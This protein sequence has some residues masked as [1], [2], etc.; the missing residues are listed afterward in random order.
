M[1][2]VKTR[3]LAS[4]LAFLFVAAAS[5]SPSLAGQNSGGLLGGGVG[6]AL[7]GAAG[8]ISGTMNGVAGSLG[9]GAGVNSAGSQF[10]GPTDTL[11]SILASP[12]SSERLFSDPA[13][14]DE[15]A[16]QLHV[17][18]AAA[19]A[20]VM[21]LKQRTQGTLVSVS[22]DAVTVATA[23]GPKNLIASDDAA[24]ALRAFVSK[25]VILRA[26]DGVHITSV[27][28]QHDAIRGIVTSVS[29]DI[30]TF[31]SP[32][33]EIHTIKLGSGAAAKLGVRMG[34]SVVAVSND[35]DQ[36]ASFGVLRIPPGSLL[37][38]AYLGVV[39]QVN[40]S[41]VTLRSGG[42]LQSFIVDA[43]T[44]NILAAL[45]G[46]TVVLAIPDGVHVKT[47]VAASMVDEL[48]ALASGQVRAGNGVMAQVVAA[49]RNR[50]TL[51][52]PNGDV[53]SYL[54]ST[55]LLKS[56]T[57]VAATLTPLDFLHAR[58]A[59]GASVFKAVDAGACVTVNAGCRARPLSG[60]VAAVDTASIAVRMANGDLHTLLGDVHGLT[61][62]VGAPVTVTPLSN[63]HAR[64]VAG[65][66]VAD[67]VDARACATINAGC[68]GMP[69]T[70]DS[71][72][73]HALTV[74]L[75]DG[76]KVDLQGSTAGLGLA[77]SLPVIVQP[78]DNTHAI[79]QASGNV[80]NLVDAN[81]C[82]T[83]NAVCAA[84][85]G[86]V[87]GA[88]AGAKVV[89]NTGTALADGGNSSAAGGCVSVNG[90]ACAAS[91]AGSGGGTGS[92]GGTGA[93][94][95]TV[96]SG[97][98]VGSGAG[99]TG[100][101]APFGP[102][103]SQPQVMAYSGVTTLAS[104]AS[105]CSQ[106]GQIVVNVID[107]KTS[108]PIAGAA[109][110]LS[111]PVHTQWVTGGGGAIRFLRLPTGT[112]VVAVQRP[113]YKSIQSIQFKLD[114]LQAAH[115]SVRMAMTTTKNGKSNQTA[116]VIRVT[117]GSRVSATN[118]R[119]IQSPTCVTKSAAAKGRSVYCSPQ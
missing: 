97:G 70:V 96:G 46:K 91:I 20:V 30:A 48:V 61:V 113:G 57:R 6:G 71:V 40:R 103:I 104:N 110:R 36:T 13:L 16:W 117:S 80:A 54:L 37:N 72:S 44:S 95:V 55:Q 108:Q 118:L 86:G 115:V 94:G 3:A 5:V 77:A 69:G 7:S 1:M 51:Q 60:S 42:A 109:V 2:Q 119:K 19:A 92:P 66:H 68:R 111:G 105:S 15:L 29:D 18:R 33:G 73:A 88:P 41:V 106:D 100:P 98:I 17:P 64:V 34:A 101:S 22:G 9:G 93:P 47:L 79:V 82:V 8:A 112:Y 78:L 53:V 116:S 26:A 14:L 52:L 45:R 99:N 35:F 28:G 11:N 31:L 75:A 4:V 81:A 74:G 83:V 49:S 38:D 114:C 24:A 62:D 107:V 85:S 67:L 58:I 27:V 12:I 63:L 32:N 76:S 21:E 23:Q 56:R 39:A 87:L 10:D 84:S 65:A 90:G 50:L 89:A 25:S 59:I 43:P 102:A